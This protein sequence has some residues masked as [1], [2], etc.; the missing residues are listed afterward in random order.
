MI[1]GALVGFDDVIIIMR[2]RSLNIPRE[3]PSRICLLG[4]LLLEQANDAD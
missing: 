2:M 4:S 1:A 3:I